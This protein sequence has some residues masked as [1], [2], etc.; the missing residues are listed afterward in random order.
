MYHVLKLALSNRLF[1]APLPLPG[2]SLN[3]LDIGTGTG[4][5]AMEFGD[6]YP[7]CMVTGNDLSPIQ[8]RWVP[9]N[10][11]FEVDDITEDWPERP[12]FDFI[13][14]RYL[15]GSI[16]NWPQL[17]QRIKEDL[18]PG[19]WV[20][21]QDIDLKHYSE[22]DSIPQGNHVAEIHD[23][24]IEACDKVGRTL[25][26]GRFLRRWAEEEGFVN[27][28]EHIFRVPLGTWPKDPRLVSCISLDASSGVA[29]ISEESVG[30][31]IKLLTHCL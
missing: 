15:A 12:P 23:L 6:E 5:W 25:V 20:E 24:L 19:G 14:S 10:V 17:M 7:E 3:V 30:L 27:V 26:P 22:D 16:S 8:P 11:Q 13:H 18:K 31:S 28:E 1:L 4:I 2:S 21:F 9:A 29:S